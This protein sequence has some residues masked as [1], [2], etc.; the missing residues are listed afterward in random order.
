M[1]TI[2]SPNYYIKT[3]ILRHS[4]PPSLLC[5]LEMSL[6]AQQ[7]RNLVDYNFQQLSTQLFYDS[8]YNEFMV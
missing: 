6:T 4:Q 3:D 2:K 7:K 1:R 5:I 8:H